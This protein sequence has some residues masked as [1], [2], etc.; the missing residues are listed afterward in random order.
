M[1]RCAAG[2][3]GAEGSKIDDAVRHAH[4]AGIGR[5]IR[6]QPP[7][8]IRVRSAH[9][10]RIEPVVDQLDAVA[11]RRLEVEAPTRDEEMIAVERTLPLEMRVAVAVIL[12]RQLGGRKRPARTLE[13]V[14]GIRARWIREWPTSF[15]VDG[16]DVAVLLNGN[17]DTAAAH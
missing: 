12:E 15:D 17:R 8:A 10:Q 7:D 6:E 14:S 4:A 9:V 13:T 11:R 3:K 16:V 1:V 5:Q 2:L